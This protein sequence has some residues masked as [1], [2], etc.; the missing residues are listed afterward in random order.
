MPP[1]VAR[2]VQSAKLA[3]FE[4]ISDLAA[5]VWRPVY[6]SELSGSMVASLLI[7]GNPYADPDPPRCLHLRGESDPRGAAWLGINSDSRPVGD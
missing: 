4:E 1:R 2:R 3:I 7:E 6:I 5:E